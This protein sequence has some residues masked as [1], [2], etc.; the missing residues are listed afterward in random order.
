MGK[1]NNRKSGCENI[2]TPFIIIVT[3][4]YRYTSR[5]VLLMIYIVSSPP[6]VWGTSFCTPLI[7]FLNSAVKPWN[8]LYGYLSLMAGY[9]ALCR[10]RYV[11]P[12]QL[13]ISRVYCYQNSGTDFSGWIFHCIWEFVSVVI[14]FWN[15]TENWLAF[16][17]SAYLC[18]FY[19]NIC[20]SENS[21]Y[22]YTGSAIIMATHILC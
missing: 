12:A 4:Q 9:L 20:Y 2:T 3:S 7:C 10:F 17:W 11:S 16:N 8:K 15:R 13:R 18:K 22:I 1:F 21:L 19:C 5:S 14:L 6:S